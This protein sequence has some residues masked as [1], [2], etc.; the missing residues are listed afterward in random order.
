M[1]LFRLFLSDLPEPVLVLFLSIVVLLLFVELPV[2]SGLLVV[3]LLLSG[4]F[5]GLFLHVVIL[6]FPISLRCLPPLLHLVISVDK[7]LTRLVVQVILLA[8]FI[9]RHVVTIKARSIGMVEH[10]LFLMQLLLLHLVLHLC[11]ERV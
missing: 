2:S 9:A 8:H 4:Q 5:F 7:V 10:F 1:D 3:L 6:R 11:L